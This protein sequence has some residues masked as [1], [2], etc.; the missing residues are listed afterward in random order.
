M[1]ESWN[2][3]PEGRRSNGTESSTNKRGTTRE[4]VIRLSKMRASINNKKGVTPL[5]RACARGHAAVVK[6]LRAAGAIESE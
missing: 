2:Q 5:G 3:P 6:V 1:D 4:K